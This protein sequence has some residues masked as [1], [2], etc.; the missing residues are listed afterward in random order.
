MRDYQFDSEVLFKFSESSPYSQ[1]PSSHRSLKDYLDKTQR[2]LNFPAIKDDIGQLIRLLIML[3]RPKTI[4]EMGSGFGHSCFWYIVDQ[5]ESISQIY[6][7]ETR[8]DLFQ[9]YSQANWPDFSQQKVKYF[10]ED[11][12]EVLKKVEDKIDFVLIDGVKGDYLEF[13]LKAEKKLSTG[14]IVLIDNSYWR[15]SFLD[16]EIR[17]SKKSA[18][19]IFDL[20]ENIKNNS[21]FTSVFLPFKDGLSVL[22]KN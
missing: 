12:F 4:F 2:E 10:N 17:E 14:A 19:N 7:T 18:K 21:S 3:N 1:I 16:K 20:H 11:A 8:K 6:L 5:L 9:Y 15:G 22:V 13:L